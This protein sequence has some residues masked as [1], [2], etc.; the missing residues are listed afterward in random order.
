MML[1]RGRDIVPKYVSEPGEEGL[2]SVASKRG[3]I[4]R[5]LQKGGLYEIREVQSALETL[6]HKTL[7]N[8]VE[9][10]AKPIQQFALG[11]I[12]PFFCTEK[13]FL[14]IKNH[15]LTRI[16]LPAANSPCG[17]PHAL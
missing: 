11:R 10:R 9:I 14:G 16:Y 13:H 2:D 8:D 17:I 15:F 3:K 6:I 12:I 4:P 7:S 1:V 5:R